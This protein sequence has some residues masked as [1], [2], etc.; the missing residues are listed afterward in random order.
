MTDSLLGTFVRDG[1]AVVQ[2]DIDG[3]D[4]AAIC[5]RLH[6][7]YD[8][9]GNPGNNI[10]PT[11][12]EIADVYNHPAVCSALTRILGPEYRMHGHRHGHRTLPGSKPQGWHKDSTVYDPTVRHPR[13]R[14]LLA[15][16]YP[17][18]VTLD[19]GPTGVI[20]RRQYIPDISDADQERT[21]EPGQTP[22]CVPAGTVVLAHNDAWH[23]AMANTSDRPRF[24]L[25]FLFERLE[26]PVPGVPA[27][28]GA[29]E[30]DGEDPF[31]LVHADVWRWLHGREVPAAL[32]WAQD[33]ASELK[34]GLDS[35]DRAV[36][37]RSA[38]ALARYGES[39]VGLLRDALVDQSNR[40]Q[41]SMGTKSPG[42]PHGINP[43]ALSSACGLSA[44]GA[45]AVS[46][47]CPLLSHASWC[48]RMMAADT[49]GNLG[50]CARESVSALVHAVSDD[51][52]RVRRHGVEALGRI[53]FADNSVVGA[54]AARLADSETSVRHNA[55]L[56]VAK[57]AVEGDGVV[58]GLQTCLG[59]PDRYVRD[60][61]VTALRRIGTPDALNVLL[62]SMV[63][64]RW[65]DLTTRKRPF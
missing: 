15:L 40:A 55:C 54:L 3:P 35:A 32:A 37:L 53:G 43:H 44:I 6:T 34:L 4:H 30:S 5:E 26:E 12:P 33:D 62:D 47:L 25:K 17:Q 58:A 13:P 61:A 10:L 1:V 39:A 52:P 46:A 56:S 65:C 29:W 2:T 18:T 9:E 24:M 21:T 60:V 51:H 45:P 20:A 57:L 50:P 64:S 19:M 31:D 38:Y 63:V 22:L 41:A 14:F 23:C 11:V 42:D 7:V 16:Y 27:D 8:S 48:V 49:L 28:A 36:A 59:D